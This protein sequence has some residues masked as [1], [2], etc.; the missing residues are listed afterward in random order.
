LRESSGAAGQ[1]LDEISGKVVVSSSSLDGS[2]GSK[3][4]G[5]GPLA[6]NMVGHYYLTQYERA[7]KDGEIIN[8]NEPSLPV[9]W[10]KIS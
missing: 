9:T 5:W 10:I 3:Q 6:N 4:G 2:S 8:F 7:L 1:D